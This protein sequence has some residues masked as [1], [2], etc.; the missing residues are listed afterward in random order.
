[1]LIYTKH[2]KPV[3]RNVIRRSRKWPIW[4]RSWSCRWWPRIIEFYT[5]W[6]T[7]I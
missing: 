1:V 2:R 3:L 5:A 6:R 7:K 4:A